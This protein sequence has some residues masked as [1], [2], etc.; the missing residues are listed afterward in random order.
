MLHF[1]YHPF[2]SLEYSS[3][4]NFPYHYF[5]YYWNT[6]SQ[7][8]AFGIDVWWYEGEHK[9]RNHGAHSCV[10]SLQMEESAYININ[11]KNCTKSN[12]AKPQRTPRR[13]RLA[14]SHCIYNICVWDSHC[15]CK[16]SQTGTDVVGAMKSE[17]P[18]FTLYTYSYSTLNES[19]YSDFFCVANRGRPGKC[20]KNQMN[21]TN[22]D[23]REEEDHWK[24]MNTLL[25]IYTHLSSAAA[26]SHNTD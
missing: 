3:I 14:T 17:V 25:S 13:N 2:H 15:I 21:K 22:A 4:R 1:S 7:G 24:I 8:M 26:A 18:P 10:V 23:E 19:H 20:A 9:W 11:L 6:S 5:Y 16:K 12:N